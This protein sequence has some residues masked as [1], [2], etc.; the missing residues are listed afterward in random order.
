MTLC[1][2]QQHFLGVKEIITYYPKIP[3]ESQLTKS[4]PVLYLSNK[5][6]PTVHVYIYW[7]KEFFL[8]DYI[9]CD[10][11]FFIY[12]NLELAF[13]FNSGLD[14][15]FDALVFFMKILHSYEYLTLEYF[16]TFD[17]IV[18]TVISIVRLVCQLKE[19]CVMIHYINRGWKK[20]TYFTFF[21][22]T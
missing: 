4:A 1:F 12:M 18:N 9:I 10:A 16:D 5:R 13:K 19:I 2:F 21:H 17:N 7:Y 6:G 22:V 20:N 15:S 11:N 3:M 8:M 14:Y